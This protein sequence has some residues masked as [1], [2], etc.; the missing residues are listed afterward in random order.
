MDIYKKL[1]GGLAVLV[2]VVAGGVWLYWEYVCGGH[3]CSLYLIDSTLSPLLWGSISLTIILIS[4]L[5]FPSKLFRQ[6]LVYIISWNIP[7]SIYFVLDQDPRQFGPFGIDRGDLAWGFGSLLFIITILYALGWH[8]Y[9]WKKGRIMGRD[10]AKLSVF[11]ISGALFYVIWQ[12][13]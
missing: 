10:F 6:W 9:E 3:K 12:L 8:I 13:F 4:L 5:V 7:L 1:N 2:G 11:L